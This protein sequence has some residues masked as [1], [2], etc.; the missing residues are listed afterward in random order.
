M[1]QQ[2]WPLSKLATRTIPEIP[3]GPAAPPVDDTPATEDEIR[4]MQEKAMDVYA[5]AA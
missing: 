3:A 5:R 1:L 4:R 2:Y